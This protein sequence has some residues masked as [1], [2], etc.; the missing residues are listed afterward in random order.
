[1]DY[2]KHTKERFFERFK[3]EITDNEYTN[4]CE[5]CKNEKNFI[6]IKTS[7]KKRLKV[8]VYFNNIYIW[9]ALSQKNNVLT[10]HPINITLHCRMHLKNKNYENKG[11]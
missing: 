9:C 10:V 4:L 1:M 3:K 2:K 7:Y 6:M 8:I 5:L 11:N